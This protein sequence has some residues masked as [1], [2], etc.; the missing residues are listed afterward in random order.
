MS[1][2]RYAVGLLS[3]SRADV[4]FKIY[5]LCNAT[6]VT[7]PAEVAAL[8]EEEDQYFEGLGRYVDIDV[9]EG[10]GDMIDW[11]VINLDNLPDGVRKIAFI[12][13]Y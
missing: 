4:W 8:F 10:T 11:Q 2:S 3:D 5:N 1:V 9:E 12:T 13:S 7:P 6:G